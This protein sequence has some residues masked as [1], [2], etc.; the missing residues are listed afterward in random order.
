[1]LFFSDSVNFSSDSVI[2]PETVLFFSDSV[3]FPATVLCFSSNS[4]SDSVNFSSDS[5]NVH[6]LSRYSVCLCTTQRALCGCF[7]PELNGREG[8]ISAGK[9]DKL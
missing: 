3:I 4:S 9:L 6:F 5:V 7:S 1:M 2:F 8:R